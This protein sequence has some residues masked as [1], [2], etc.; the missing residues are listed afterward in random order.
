MNRPRKNNQRR[1]ALVAAADRV[2][3]LPEAGAIA[4]EMALRSATIGR[5]GLRSQCV[6]QLQE[7]HSGTRFTELRT[8]Q[9]WIRLGRFPFESTAGCYIL[10][11]KRGDRTGFVVFDRSHTRP[12]SDRRG[13]G[14]KSPKPAVI[15]LRTLTQELERRGFAL[16]L[17]KG[18]TVA[19]T[20]SDKDIHFTAEEHRS[21]EAL[22]ALAQSCARLVITEP[23]VSDPAT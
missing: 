10:S 18:A 1:D 16:H 7:Q 3:A 5:W 20:T 13:P 9:D 19:I 8:R 23:H 11:A 6:L 2:L 12:V 17:H 4:T 21:R 14:F 15:W 22:A